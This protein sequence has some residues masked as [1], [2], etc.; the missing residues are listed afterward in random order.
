MRIDTNIDGTPNVTRMQ[1]IGFWLKYE[2]IVYIMLAATVIG[3][4]AAVVAITLIGQNL[5]TS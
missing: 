1:A 3:F 4:I 2:L 5:I